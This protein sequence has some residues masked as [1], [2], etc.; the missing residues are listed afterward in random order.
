[1]ANRYHGKPFLKIAE[2]FVM[3]AIGMIEPATEITL[4]KMTPKLQ[5]IYGT[6]GTWDEIT[7]KVLNLPEGIEAEIRGLWERNR[8]IAEKENHVLSAEEFTAAYV[9]KFFSRTV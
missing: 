3:K 8:G 9:D 7:R 2:S 4:E 6:T 5:E 1:M